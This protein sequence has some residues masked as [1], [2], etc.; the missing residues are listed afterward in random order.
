M[1]FKNSCRTSNKKTIREQATTQSLSPTVDR[2]KVEK[3]LSRIECLM[4]K[5]H[6]RPNCHLGAAKI[7][8]LRY[9]ERPFVP[10]RVRKK[11]LGNNP[12]RIDSNDI[13]IFCAQRLHLSAIE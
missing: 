7:L 8:A 1:K 9:V 11:D 3:H 4:L 2:S 10:L 13:A 6:F 12:S 5:R